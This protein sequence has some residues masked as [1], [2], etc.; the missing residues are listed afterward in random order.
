MQ[1]TYDFWLVNL[2]ICDIFYYMSNLPLI[3]M[4]KKYK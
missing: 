4:D 1:N 3:K 2:K